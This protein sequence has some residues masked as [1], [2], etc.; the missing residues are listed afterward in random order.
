MRQI[1]IGILLGVPLLTLGQVENDVSVV[2]LI[3]EIQQ[4]DKKGN[5]MSL[6]WWIPNEYWRIALKGNDQ[7]PVE[8]ID[9]VETAFRDYVL[10]LACDLSIHNDGTMDYTSEEDL[11][12]SITILD[13]LG[14]KHF[15]L[16]NN[17]ID[18]QALSV[19]ENMKPFFAQALGQMGRGINFFFF[20][21]TDQSGK[22]LIDG[23]A[24]GHFTVS[25]SNSSFLWKL[26][27]STLL[28]PK[29]CPVDKERM[30]ATWSYCPIHGQKLED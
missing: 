22:N 17:Q 2:D 8:T 16:P 13:N 5:N 21:V 9:Y 28:P 4:W 26:P 1:F 7:I 15:P 30:K 3:K 10:I 24:Q 25:H 23:K 20:S 19:A 27:L 12:K 6:T 14:K 18:G 11:A 29:F